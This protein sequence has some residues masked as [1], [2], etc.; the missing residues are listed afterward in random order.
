MFKHSKFGLIASLVLLVSGCVAGAGDE[1]KGAASNP[2]TPTGV[3]ATAGSARVTLSW[4]TVSGATS[5]NIY[6]ATQSGVTKTNTLA[7]GMTH[8]NAANPYVHTGLTNGTP[9]ILLSRR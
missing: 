3:T 4:S 8:S 6:M 2:A 9:I 5:Y 1:G 7:G